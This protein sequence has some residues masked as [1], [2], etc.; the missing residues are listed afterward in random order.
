ML[1]SQFTATSAEHPAAR[2][3][4]NLALRVELESS[5]RLCLDYGV[6][7]DLNVEPKH[8]L[9]LVDRNWAIGLLHRY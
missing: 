3:Q 5:R 6:T 4:Q 9:G 7:G 8:Q 2:Q 1:P